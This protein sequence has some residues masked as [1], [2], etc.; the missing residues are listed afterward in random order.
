MSAFH[1]SPPESRQAEKS[2]PLPLAAPIGGMAEI[3]KSFGRR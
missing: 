2:Q 3:V 1:G